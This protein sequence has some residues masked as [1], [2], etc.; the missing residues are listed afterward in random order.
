MTNEEFIKSVSFPDEEW[1]D[2]VG[3]EGFYVVSSLGRVIT[4]QRYV[5]R[6]GSLILIPFKIKKASIDNVRPKYKR[7]SMVLYKNSGEHKRITL[8]RIVAAAFIP[9]PYNYPSI[10]HI[11]GN[12]FNNCVNNLRWCTTKMNQNNPI[13]KERISKSKLGVYNTWRSKKVVQLKDG[14]LINTYNSSC[15][16]K[17][18]GYS[19]QSVND[20]CRGKMKQHKGF[21][22]MFLSDYEALIKSKNESIQAKDNYQQEQPPQLQEPQLPLQFEP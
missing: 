15:E 13:T 3:F 6:N 7:L 17:R 19:Q 10:D 14:A 22:W 8:H 5:N 2:V 12:T 1:R 21:Q 20:C 11:D 4:L 16:A 18:N 9:N